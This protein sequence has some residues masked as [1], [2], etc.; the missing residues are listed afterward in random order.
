MLSKLFQRR[1]PPR[2]QLHSGLLKLPLELRYEIYTY[3]FAYSMIY[4][5]GS[6][7]LSPWDNLLFSCRQVKQEM[8][9]IPAS[10]IIAMVDTL[11]TE[12][13][14][15][16]PLCVSTIFKDGHISE[17]N[18]GIPRSLFHGRD[19][20]SQSSIS[21]QAYVFPLFRLFTDTFTLRIHDDGSRLINNAEEKQALCYLYMQIECFVW[22]RRARRDR[23]LPKHSPDRMHTS[24]RTFFC[25][26]PPSSRHFLNTTKLVLRWEGSLT[27]EVRLHPKTVVQLFHAVLNIVM[28][29]RWP[30]YE[31]GWGSV[32][33]SEHYVHSVTRE[34]KR[35]FR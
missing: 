33:E 12:E 24:G 13:F 17:I 10:P 35:R 34:H 20:C 1:Q 16:H 26:K 19:Y 28:T 21:I 14:P 30:K 29:P 6:E 31:L 27:D 3:V 2:P 7:L 4:E 5:L 32:R 15:Q 23:R 9:S 8:E 11:W 18:V 25:E 22:R